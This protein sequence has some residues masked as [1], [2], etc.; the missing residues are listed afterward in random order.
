MVNDA[1]VGK[2]IQEKDRPILMHL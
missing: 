2:L 1:I